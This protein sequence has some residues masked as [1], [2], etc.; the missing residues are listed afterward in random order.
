[1][2][3]LANT[4]QVFVKPMAIHFAARSVFRLKNHVKSKN[5]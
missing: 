1:M 3:V 4:L 5:K 2:Q